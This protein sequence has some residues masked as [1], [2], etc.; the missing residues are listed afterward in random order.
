MTVTL[1]NNARRAFTLIE[2]LVVIAIIAI[3]AA[4][5]F[6]VF[7]QAREKARQTACLSNMK[8]LGLAF[9]MYATDYDET[10]PVNRTC[11]GGSAPGYQT[12]SEGLRTTGWA[13][14]IMPY[15]KNT[16]ILK[17]P[18]DAT[19]VLRPEMDG[20]VLSGNPNARTN[21]NRT[22]YAKSNNLGNVPPP[23]GYTVGDAQV[24]F[25]ADTIVFVE[26][27]PNQGGGANGLEQVGAVWNI[28]RDQVEQPRDPCTG[29]GGISGVG[30][31]NANAN[32]LVDDRNDPSQLQ[33][34]RARVPSKQHVNGANY[35]FTDGHAKWH[36]PQQI[37]GQCGFT[38]TSERGAVGG[39]P[40]FLL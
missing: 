34:V 38:G 20:Y 3:L 2:L 29:N 39:R 10:F 40:S 1:K 26:W 37:E 28:Y 9:R 7:A 22:S 17:C 36:R 5:L 18:N 24:N 27:A 30:R 11:V 32:P 19:P 13:D 23:F 25:P 21:V 31:P 33:A 8:Q 12:C 4:I 35:I 6:P 16:G 15:I 14:M